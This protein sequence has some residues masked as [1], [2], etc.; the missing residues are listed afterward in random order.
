MS[1]FW[2]GASAGFVMAGALLA[3]AKLMSGLHWNPGCAGY[4]GGC[5]C[6]RCQR[7]DTEVGGGAADSNSTGAY[8]R[9]HGMAA[10]AVGRFALRDVNAP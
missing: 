6:R 1:E 5:M 10:D 7:R 4:E 3:L 8:L 9:R 2:Q